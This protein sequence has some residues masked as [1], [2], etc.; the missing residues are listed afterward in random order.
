M[1]FLINFIP[2]I[3]MC[4]QIWQS[5]LPVLVPT[6][7]IWS[8][9]PWKKAKK[10]VLRQVDFCGLLIC[11]SVTFKL[12]MGKNLAWYFFITRSN[13]FL[14]VH[15]VYLWYTLRYNIITHGWHNMK[16]PCDNCLRIYNIYP[17]TIVGCLKQHPYHW[18]RFKTNKD[19]NY[20][21]E[22]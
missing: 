11:F 6:A 12:S 22:L 19:V 17:I 7:N 2:I 15:N 18:R 13:L 21:S 8:F 14:P 5:I 3:K 4:N 9:Y 16:G 20:A 10:N 1:T